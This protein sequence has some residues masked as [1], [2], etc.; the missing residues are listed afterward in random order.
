[1]NTPNRHYPLP[2]K[3]HDVVDDIND[4]RSTF[5]AI[6]SDVQDSEERIEELSETV[7]DLENRAV[8]LSYSI[9]NSEIQ[10]ISANRYLVVNS[11]GDGFECL[12]G[13]GDVGGKLGQSSIKKTDAN[14]DTAWGN[15][16]EISKNGMTVQENSEKSQSNETHIFADE[17]EIENEEQ[18][19]KIE[20]T[21]CQAKSDLEA[22]NNGSVI[23]CDNAEEIEEEL[24]IATHEN[25]GLVKV[26]SGFTNDTGTIS[27]PIISKA[28]TEEF[29]IIKTGNGLINNNGIISRD[30]INPATYSNFGVVKLGENL[31]INASG[32]MEID[33]MGNAATIYDLG[34]IKICNNGIVD[35]EEQTLQYRLFVTEDL[36]IQFK[37]DFEPRADFSFVLELVSY[38]SYIVAFNENLNPKMTTLPV[39]RGTTK[40]KFTKKLGV[41]SYGFEISRLDAPEP[42]LLTPKI[43]S[44]ISSEFMV[45]SEGGSWLPNDILKTDYEGYCDI[46]ELNFK[47]ETLVCVDY[48]NYLSRSSS[49]AMGEFVLKGSSDGK[50]WT[51]L[52]YKNGEIIYGKIY[53]ELKGCFRYFNL[54]IGYTSDDNKPGGVT[55]W[56]TQI[57]NNESEIIPIT[58]YMGS[59]ETAFATMTTSNNIVEGSA[60]NITDFSSD[61]YL[62]MEKTND[63]W[64]KFEFPTAK[65]ANILELNYWFY[66]S[67]WSYNGDRQ[68][69]WFQLLG[70]NDD[71]NWAL[72][73]ERQY[74][75]RALE[76]ENNVLFFEFNNQTAYKYYKFV[77]I[78]T[79]SGDD[80]WN[81]CGL[82][83]YRRDHGKHNF[84]NL[85]PTLSSN[86]Q[87]GYE[88]TASSY[89]GSHYPYHA[90]DNS[91]GV[92]NKWLSNSG[93]VNEAWLK[94]ELPEA[95]AVDTFQIQSP[96][97]EY[98]DRAPKKFKIQGSNDDTFWTDLVSETNLSWAQN[99]I[100]KWN[101]ENE[102]AFRFYRIF[103]E[104]SN[105]ANFVD[106]G[107]FSLGNTIYEY[108]R[109]LDKYDYLVPVL[110]G[111]TT[112]ASDGTYVVSASSCDEYGQVW[113]PFSRS[114]DNFL[115]LAGSTTGWIKIQLPE[116]R[117]ANSMRIGSRNDSYAGDTP[118]NYSLYGSN[119][120]ATWDILFSVENSVSWSSSELRSHNFGNETAYLYYRLNFSN[121]SLRGICSVA[122]WDLII[123]K[124]IQEY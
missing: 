22:I 104:E 106:I 102:T 110:S 38:D 98:R 16:L 7:S 39:S 65:I 35:I 94:I 112:N 59:N 51:T 40:I 90:F 33:D 97:E 74:Q 26:G 72:L 45:T 37:L 82:K 105:G 21:N 75:G 46:R 61:T 114:H 29:G 87:D 88:V 121:P 13:G 109:Y 31:S 67:S 79:N 24:S 15:V 34:R 11:D 91:S 43:D 53:T 73:L 32:Q 28:T 99:Q 8:H 115:E 85:V 54:K 4:L 5:G 18:L 113:Y 58:P 96:N 63:N 120:G 123:N 57:D 69:N 52:I 111:M 118:R 64:I 100:R 103:I 119:D 36:V 10:N 77:C 101:I 89:Y 41:P 80:R 2:N 108:K 48:V 81:I 30:T 116:A 19:P 14:F 6:D 49:V 23:F 60:A 27:A 124:L 70:S 93:D 55:L 92:D 62:I 84:Y 25:F 86:S 76:K 12:D 1:M 20:L 122:R 47:F 66:G 42:V 95:V 83:L 3:N 9:E 56:G 117:I 68:P 44:C 17:S 78:A 107:E 71:E 50:N